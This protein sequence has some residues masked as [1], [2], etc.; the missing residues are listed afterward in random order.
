MHGARTLESG[1]STSVAT[2][3]LPPSR[4]DVGGYRCK[5]CGGTVSTNTGIAY[6]GLRCTRREF[7]Q[8]AR[9]RV[10]GVSISATARVT[11]R[12]RNTVARWLERASRAAERF[13]RQTLRDF[14][15][16]ELQAD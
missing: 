6:S 15:I 16:V 7:D 13:N 1:A 8:V 5:I 4:A 2:A 12:S 11:G 9:L 14:E 3:G 10:E